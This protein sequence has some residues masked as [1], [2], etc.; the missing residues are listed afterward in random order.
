[1]QYRTF[2]ATGQSVSEVG[3]GTWQLGGTEWGD[4]SD[5]EALA[6]LAAAAEAGVTLF[7]TADIYG[8][9]RS[10]ELIG[11]FLHDSGQR[12]RF[13]LATKFGRNPVP[14]WPDNFR[15]GTI[16]RH[17]EGS[18]RR[19]KV[20]AVDLLQCHCLPMEAMRD[21]T[22][23]QT[24]RE[25]QAEGRIRAFGAS[26]E[27]M[28]EALACLR[29]PGL[30]SLQIIFNPFRLK[31]AE[32][33]FQD[34]RKL[35]VSLIARLPLASGLFSG[36]MTASTVFPESD[37]RHFNRDGQRFNVGETFAG[38]SLEHA[39]PA[40]ERLKGL[41]PGGLPL[42]QFALRWCLDHEEITSVIPGARRP[43]QAR[44]NAAASD[45]KNLA[46]A[47]HAAVFELYYDS[48]RDWIRG[49]C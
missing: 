31:P 41:V 14:G 44:E 35:G 9:G 47:V 12:D 13:F 3:L 17:L 38:L 28:D 4:V 26:V 6:T 43:D 16:R 8:A 23:W 42:A 33:L 18:L 7:D 46:P 11:R 19:L 37:H 45:L 30:A 36:R 49:P 25:L 27:S 29:V 15:P 21:G 24:L 39:L 22:V 34:A 5:Q 10:E 48:V 32:V 20:D 2:A 40:V 1:M